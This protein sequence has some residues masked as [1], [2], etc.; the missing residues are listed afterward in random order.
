MDNINKISI[1]LVFF[2][3]SYFY[4]FVYAP[5]IIGEL[6]TSTFNGKMN[7]IH[8][9]CIY[10]CDGDDVCPHLTQYRGDSY[11]I[12]SM[13][14]EKL[15]KLKKCL[16]TWWSLTHFITY[17]V[18]GYLFPE[19]FWPLFLFGVLFEIYERYMYRCEDGLDIIYNTLGLI[20]GVYLKTNNIIM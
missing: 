3:L 12:G 2:I 19:Y 18:L 20:T 13:N 5:G 11:Y 14:S 10:G 9:S 1:L 17:L 6:D 16:V 8:E 4:C 15:K 7:K